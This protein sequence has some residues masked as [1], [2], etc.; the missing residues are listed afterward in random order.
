MDKEVDF[1]EKVIRSI[2]G[3]SDEVVIILSIEM[4]LKSGI[5][6][7]DKLLIMARPNE[8]VIRKGQDEGER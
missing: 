7:G 5:E 6:V 2:D 1:Y 4:L 3:E 8:L